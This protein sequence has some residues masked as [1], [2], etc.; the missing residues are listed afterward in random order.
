MI[1]DVSFPEFETRVAILKQRCKERGVSPADEVLGYIAEYI[2]KNIR[3]LE[4]AL[5]LVLASA[6][7]KQKP[8]NTEDV[9]K[10]LKHIISRPKKVVTPKQVIQTIAGFYEVSEKDLVGKNRRKEIA[11]PRQVAM[12]IMRNTLKNSYPF[13]GSK[14]GGRDHTTIMHACVKIG[15]A[16]K[17]DDILREE[18][19]LITHQL[20]NE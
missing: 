12:Y 5:N 8:L 17:V 6:R 9:K 3:E 2:K 16:I 13:I 4:G 18:M 11:H 20:Y 7:T 10:I 19:D 14:I 1:T 15:E